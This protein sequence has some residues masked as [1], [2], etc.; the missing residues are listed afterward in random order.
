MKSATLLR[1]PS[2]DDG[3]FGVILLN[4]N[5]SFCTGELPWRDNKKGISCIPVGTYIASWF[6]SPKHGWCYQLKDVPNRNMIQIH[7][8]NYMADKSSGKRSELE[9]C[10]ALGKSIGVLN[11]QTAVLSSK[12]AIS[13]FE[14]SMNK[15][16]FKLSII[17]SPQTC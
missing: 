5:R 6:N 10:I 11:G 9:G 13:E 3:T 16:D 4:D 1:N 14:T 17:W 2:T 8:A 15:E 12:Q 7:S